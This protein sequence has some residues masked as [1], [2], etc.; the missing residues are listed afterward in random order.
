MARARNYKLEYQRRIQ[1]GIERGLTRKQARGHAG[2]ILKRTPPTPQASPVLD[3]QGEVT[4][5]LARLSGDRR[6]KL[7]VTF[8]DGTTATIGG[9]KGGQRANGLRDHLVDLIDELGSLDAV[10]EYYG[11]GGRGAVTGYQVVWQ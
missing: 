7:Q 6:A 1:R 5:Y 11:Y 9:K 8:E 2:D 10:A 4:G 3:R